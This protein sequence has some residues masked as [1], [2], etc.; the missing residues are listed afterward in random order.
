MM[1]NYKE[2]MK[3]KIKAYAKTPAYREFLLTKFAIPYSQSEIAVPK[4]PT[5]RDYIRQIRKE[6][7][8]TADDALRKHLVANKI[9][10]KESDL[11][12]IDSLVHSAYDSLKAEQWAL[13]VPDDPIFS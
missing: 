13:G 7:G 8:P 1:D 5:V 9:I 12:N 3:E 4:K 2:A 6:L 11:S 10:R